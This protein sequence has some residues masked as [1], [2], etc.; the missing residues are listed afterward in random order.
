M[1]K[2]TVLFVLAIGFFSLRSYNKA[3]RKRQKLWHHLN[4]AKHL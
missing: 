2:L 1:H 4:Q 3:L